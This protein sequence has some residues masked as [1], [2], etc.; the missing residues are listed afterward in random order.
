MLVSCTVF[1]LSGRGLC[2]G[3]IT[4]PEE[5]YW[6]WC[7]SQCDQVKIKKNLYTHSEQVGRR[8]KDYEKITTG[9]ICL[10]VHM[11]W[12]IARFMAQKRKKKEKKEIWENKIRKYWVQNERH[13]PRKYFVMWLTYAR[14]RIQALFY[15]AAVTP[16]AWPFA[17]LNTSIQCKWSILVLETPV[18]QGCGT[19]SLGD[20]C[21]TFRD[22][23]VV[24]CSSVQMSILTDIPM[25]ILHRPFNLRRWDYNVV[26]KRRAPVTQWR[27]T[28]SGKKGDL[29]LHHRQ[30]AK[31]LAFL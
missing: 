14:H 2:D 6:L 23:V 8:G 9:S 1:V 28:T 11:H 20:W 18:L 19:A 31:K 26:S 10:Q 17:P 25:S 3:P 16:V 22:S 24:S 30:K 4:R 27:S 15:T 5:S 29:K 7:V 12:Y 13:V 21:R